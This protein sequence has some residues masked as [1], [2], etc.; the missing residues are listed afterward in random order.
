[1]QF[2]GC[3]VQV[4]SWCSLFLS[5]H[6]LGILLMRTIL[7][8]T[9]VYTNHLVEFTYL[10]LKVAVPDKKHYAYVSAHR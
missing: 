5:L 9:N 3:G 4:A 2:R 8:E 7:I 10:R 1:M 6:V